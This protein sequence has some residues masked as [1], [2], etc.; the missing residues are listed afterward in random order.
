MTKQSFLKQFSDC[1]KAMQLNEAADYIHSLQCLFPMLP[2]TGLINHQAYLKRLAQRTAC[3]ELEEALRNAPPWKDWRVIFAEFE[4]PYLQRAARNSMNRVYKGPN[5]QKIGE[6]D[7]WI[8]E[9][10]IAYHYIF[11][12][13]PGQIPDTTTWRIFY[14]LMNHVD[15]DVSKYRR[16]L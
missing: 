1:K 16:K 8:V 5:G 2:K 11:E 7:A 14:Q 3:M 6:A 10:W 4:W 13:M 9:M 12:R 15:H